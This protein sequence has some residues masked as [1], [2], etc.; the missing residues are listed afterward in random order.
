MVDAKTNVTGNYSLNVNCGYTCQA[1]TLAQIDATYITCNAAMLTANV[2]CATAYDWRYRAVGAASWINLNATSAPNVAISGLTPGTQYEFQV[3]IQCCNGSASAWSASETFSTL[4]GGNGCSNPITVACGGTYT[5]NN[6]SC[7]D[8][9]DGYWGNGI[10][11]SNYTSSEVVHKLTLSNATNLTLT[12]SNLTANLELVVLSACN[13]YNAIAISANSGTANEQITLNNLPAGMYWIVVDAKTNV[14]GNYSLNVNC[15]S[16]CPAPTLYEIDAVEVTCISAKLTASVS[17]ATQYDWRYRTLGAANWIDL[18]IGAAAF[19]NLSNLAPGTQYE[20]QVK[21][22]CSNGVES[23][24]SASETFTTLGA[25]NG[26]CANPIVVTCNNSYPGN[27]NS[28]N[29]GYDGYW[30]NGIDVTGYNGSEVVYKFVLGSASNVTFSLTNLTANL[31]LLVLSTCNNYSAI[32]AGLNTGTN[33]EY[34]TMPNLAAGT[35][36]IVVDAR[37]SAI[38]SYVL[39]VNCGNTANSCANPI[40]VQC[41]TPYAG[42]NSGGGSNYTMYKVGSNV[43][44]GMT[45]P[46]IVHRLV[47]TSTS[48]VTINLTGLS[49]DLDLYLL[50]SCDPNNGLAVSER[51]NNQS[52][53]IVAPNLTAGTYY[54]V[55]DGWNNSVSN[56]NLSVTCSG[57][58][59][60]EPPGTDLF[61]AEKIRKNS[62][63]LFCNVY[64]LSYNWRYRVLGNTTWL[65]VGTQGAT[66]NL[67]NLSPA[68]TYEYQV[69]LRCY[70]GSVGNWSA[71]KTFTT[72]DDG[73]YVNSCS[74]PV[75]L[76]CGIPY[77]GN[78]ADGQDEFN[79]YRIGNTVY[80]GLNGAEGIHLFT[81][82]NSGAATITLTGLSNDLD[83]YLLSACDPN[84]AVAVSE[85]QGTA[86]EQLTFANLAAGT[87]IVAVDGFN[88][89]ASAYTLNLTCS[90]SGN[91]P[92]N[93]VCGATAL[94]TT[95]DCVQMIANN[96]GATASSSPVAPSDCNNASLR[97]VWFTTLIPSG[98]KLV[99]NTAAGTLTNAVMAIYVG[100]NCNS[101]TYIG[102]IDDKANGDKMPDVTINGATGTRVYLRVWGY[103][104]STGTFSICAKGSN[105]QQRPASES[106]I[107]A[108]GGKRA[109][110][111]TN[112]TTTFSVT[113][114]S[115]L[116]LFPIPTTSHLD[117]V[118]QLRADAVVEVRVLDMNGR[119]VR[120]ALG[121]GTQAGHLTHRLEVDDLP[122]GTYV[123][124]LQAGSEVLTGRFVKVD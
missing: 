108:A 55:V 44:A 80:N 8:S 5:G 62:A 21:V 124:R 89:A 66:L 16:N 37:N 76:Y 75:M 67:T 35:Y 70:N 69:A 26:S 25:G 43:S 29:N 58:S 83:L 95:G 23:A 68:T 28:C 34:V 32:A 115:S 22:I 85:N 61:W 10:D 98:N 13:N 18:P 33:S 36:W 50:S 30:G 1:P 74:N 20:F 4:T 57:S 111:R 73:N 9:W 46:E 110:D 40:N 38:G 123:L 54:I 103:N 107:I 112:P 86:N 78:S 91:L 97:D 84:Y 114:Q 24:W 113:D 104:G 88:G 81:L 102:C 3:A 101:L 109:E 39:G 2:S 93:E 60:C 122:Q 19:V 42:S 48:A 17:G 92:N 65:T 11:V 121:L 96:I 116:Q 94:P 118:A 105:T 14:T 99:I 47:L 27:N 64:A 7:V 106:E 6:N 90:G 59:G 77:T 120:S 41:G 82:A 87:Y 117:V 79:T 63:N 51:S 72:L 100:S 119:I 12:L 53:Q 52:E 31:D 15:S 45:G 56:Y 71:T 49:A